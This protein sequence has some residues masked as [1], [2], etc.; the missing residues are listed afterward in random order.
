[1]RRPTRQ[2][3]VVAPDLDVLDQLVQ[4]DA[5]RNKFNTQHFLPRNKFGIIRYP[6]PLTSLMRG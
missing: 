6:N 4:G 5:L 3:D 1:M 2:L